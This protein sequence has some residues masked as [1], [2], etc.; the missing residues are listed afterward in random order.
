MYGSSIILRSGLSQTPRPTSILNCTTANRLIYNDVEP[1]EY[2]VVQ[3]RMQGGGGGGCSGCLS[4]P[5][6]H[7]YYNYYA[8][9][10]D[11]N[12]VK[13][14]KLPQTPMG[15]LTALPHT[16]GKAPPPLVSSTL[17]VSRTPPSPDQLTGLIFIVRSPMKRCINL[18]MYSCISRMDKVYINEPNKSIATQDALLTR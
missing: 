10:C 13:V 4:P 11:F 15:E 16:T 8:M 2:K 9:F 12:I 1:F 18:H 17:I 7:F 5:P 6:P 14:A 3:W